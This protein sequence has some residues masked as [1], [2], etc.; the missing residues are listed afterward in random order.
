MC[1]FTWPRDRILES[2]SKH[3]KYFLS[4]PSDDRLEMDV[5]SERAT[6]HRE[7]LRNALYSKHQPSPDVLSFVPNAS[8]NIQR[9]ENCK[10]RTDIAIMADVHFVKCF[11]PAAEFWKLNAKIRTTQHFMFKIQNKVI[12]VSILGQFLNVLAFNYSNY[13]SLSR[14]LSWVIM[15][16][17]VT[18]TQSAWQYRSFMWWSHDTG[19]VK[20]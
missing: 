10:T 1:H 18:Q 8:N 7:W 9:S 13:H 17:V 20:F 5:S 4:P 2:I 14:T 11:T 19:C 6:L 3:K 15:T 16:L 12:L